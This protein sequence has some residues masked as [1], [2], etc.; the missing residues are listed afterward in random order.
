MSW[1]YWAGLCHGWTWGWG[2]GLCFQLTLDSRNAEKVAA[3]HYKTVD[4][5]CVLGNKPCSRLAMWNFSYLWLTCDEPYPLLMKAVVSLSLS[6]FI[7]NFCRSILG[8]PTV[9]MD[10]FGWTMA[11][12]VLSTESISI[13][14]PGDKVQIILI[15]SAWP[16]ANLFLTSAQPV[17]ASGGQWWPMVSGELELWP[18]LITRLPS[19][20]VLL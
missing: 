5:C 7:R 10:C 20:P 16:P 12:H 2:W 11:E 14:K 9:Q 1:L 6:I 3:W 15:G 17:V 4:I 13:T 18:Q 19:C 8:H